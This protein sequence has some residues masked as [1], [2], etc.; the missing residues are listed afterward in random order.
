VSEADARRQHERHLAEIQR[1]G[2]V[3]RAQ[4]DFMSRTPGATIER[5]T[6]GYLVDTDVVWG[7]TFATECPVAR[8][9]CRESSATVVRAA[10]IGV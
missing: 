7:V 4:R 10:Q 6:I 3:E 1:L 8:T 9:R 2:L 5:W